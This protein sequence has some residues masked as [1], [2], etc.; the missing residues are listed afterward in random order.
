MTLAAEYRPDNGQ[1]LK[2]A[3]TR[4]SFVLDDVERQLRGAKKAKMDLNDASRA[5]TKAARS[6]AFSGYR[7]VDDPAKLIKS[8][9]S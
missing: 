8:I 6:R 3:C 7:D 4:A 1:Q 2:A 5:A 9:A